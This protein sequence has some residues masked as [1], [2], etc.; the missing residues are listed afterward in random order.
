MFYLSVGV[1][2]S[3]FFA[4]MVL[5]VCP[6]NLSKKQV[7]L[8]WQIYVIALAVLGF[9]INPGPL[10][11]LYKAYQEI[12]LYRS[13]SISIT[14]S[15]LILLNMFY[16]FVSKTNHN[17]WHVFIAVVVWGRC[18]GGILKEYIYKNKYYTKAIILYFLAINGGCFIVHLLS[19]IRCSLATAIWGYAYYV[20]YKKNKKVFYCIMISTVFL[21][22]F[23]GILLGLTVL[24]EYVL[25]KKNKY[26]I[27]SIILI[28]GFFIITN[29]NIML[30][31]LECFSGQYAEF[32]LDKWK[33][34]AIRN[35]EFQQGREMM[36]RILGAF[37][38]GICIFLTK[39]KNKTD[40]YIIWWFIV[41]MFVGFKM[42]I[43]FERLPYAI[44]IGVLPLLNNI[45]KINSK[46]KKFFLT[47][48]GALVLYAQVVWGIYEVMI[49]M[50]FAK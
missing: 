24:Y 22:L 25:K 20:W 47:Y 41:F 3:I 49:W 8:F 17:G 35:Y 36:L 27:V 31:V 50:D 37:Y 26:R 2:A 5:L 16:W 45:M 18:I 1:L 15:P 28:A 34:Y 6:V 32:L 30:Y 44:G 13:G 21:H 19:G 9:H 12:D 39:A 48:A 43:L 23:G 14:N 4:T 33:A 40:N 11:D 46:P 38:F 10:L 29:T 42:S 7:L